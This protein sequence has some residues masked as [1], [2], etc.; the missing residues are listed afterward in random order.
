MTRDSVGGCDGIQRMSDK[1]GRQPQERM[2]SKGDNL[3][4]GYQ[5]RKTTSREDVKQGRQ[6]REDVKQ[7]KTTSMKD[8]T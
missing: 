5:E 2:S 7:R 8:D 1:Q 4:R 3:M 6:P